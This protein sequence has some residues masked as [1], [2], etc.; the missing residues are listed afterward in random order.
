MMLRPWPWELPHECWARWA[1]YIAQVTTAA[2]PPMI[3][4]SCR[5][6][7]RVSWSLAWSVDEWECRM[8]SDGSWLL[9]GIIAGCFQWWSSWV[10]WSRPP[11][12][13]IPDE[14]MYAVNFLSTWFR[15]TWD[16]FSIMSSEWRWTRWISL[17]Q[18]SLSL[19]L[20]SAVSFESWWVLSHGEF[21]F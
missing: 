14:S 3:Q 18:K 11:T 15:G 21:P 17:I 7:A 5:V 8:I 6:C 12:L 4:N 16:S 9:R 2:S 1:R 10:L 13:M 19:L 20:K